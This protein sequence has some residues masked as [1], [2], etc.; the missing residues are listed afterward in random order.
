MADPDEQ[1]PTSTFKANNFI[2]IHDLTPQAR[3]LWVSASIYDCLGY[4]P[5]E[6]LQTSTYEILHPD[7]YTRAMVA[8]R[9]NVL[10]DMVAT[11]VVV[12]FRAKDGTY[13]AN[14]S[15]F[16]LCY[17]FIVNCTTIVDPAA[18][19][20]SVIEDHYSP[21]YFNMFDPLDQLTNRC[22]P[23]STLNTQEFERIRRHH[24]AFTS[25]TWKTD[26][27]APEARACM[28]L[29]RFSRNLG[30]MYA[31]PSCKLILQ[32][33]PDEIIGK[34]FLLFIR[35]DDLGTFVEQAD[36]AKTSTVMTNMRF[37]FQSP[38]CRNEIPI[39]AMLFGCAD[40][41]VAI[42]RRSRPFVRKQM[43]VSTEQFEFVNSRNGASSTSSSLGSSTSGSGSLRSQ[44]QW[45]YGSS[46]ASSIDSSPR[47]VH[48][49]NIE[50]RSLDPKGFRPPR[51]G[52]RSVPMGSIENIQNLERDQ[53]RF[54]PLSSVVLSD[55]TFQ[56]V[57]RVYQFREVVQIDSDEDEDGE[58]EESVLRESDDDEN[59]DSRT[60]DEDEDGDQLRFGGGESDDDDD[61][62]NDNGYGHGDMSERSGDFGVVPQ[63]PIA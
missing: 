33:D 8:H 17:D 62:D 4:T 3:T 45:S 24:E 1:P 35:A 57:P 21:A 30:V 63:S 38:N 60:E 37:W 7:D 25:G 26:E 58:E 55:Q 48:V 39:E 47:I 19:C 27:L 52:M 11:Q 40:G 59:R 56:P 13:V 44:T 16:S 2:S 36:L 20:L 14:T 50:P 42:L 49:P 34:P 22:F 5:E 61:D 9:E 6:F 53:S 12:R 54:R 23:S 46:P 10:N 29:N 15:F 18:E 43:I 32:V 51:L 41:V 31:S 28:I